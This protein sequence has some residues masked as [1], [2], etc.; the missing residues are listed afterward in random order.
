MNEWSL[1]EVEALENAPG[2]YLASFLG[3]GSPHL[4]V[5]L[6]LYSP[7]KARAQI[8][9]CEVSIS[10][11]NADG[12]RLSPGRLRAIPFGQLTAMSE[13]FI[14]D[15]ENSGGF[16]LTSPAETDVLEESY[17]FEELRKEWPKGDLNKFS[18]AVADV[19]LSAIA[20]STPPKNAVAERFSTSKATAGRMIAK[21]RDLG[22]LNVSSVGGR[23]KD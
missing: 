17:D 2:Y 6:T 19:Y 14:F 5:V 7:P 21:A 23:P 15:L 13:P 4:D 8:E 20:N 10:A 11:I 9:R 18:N 22:I 3:E 12:D 1:L 16:T